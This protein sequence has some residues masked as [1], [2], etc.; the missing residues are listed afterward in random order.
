MYF[1][2]ACI[3]LFSS[4]DNAFSSTRFQLTGYFLW[5]GSLPATAQPGQDYIRV[6]FINSPN[7]YIFLSHYLPQ[8]S[9]NSDLSIYHLPPQLDH[10]LY[11]G[12]GHVHLGH[13]CHTLTQD[14]PVVENTELEPDHLGLYL[15][16]VL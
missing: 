7:T 10:Q 8:L 3:T 14:D 13:H 11:G 4:P 5:E 15:R 9:L 1:P 6:P 12:R 16:Q 2:S